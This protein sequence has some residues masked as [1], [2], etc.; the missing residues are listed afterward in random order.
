[1]T[2]SRVLNG[3]VPEIRQQLDQLPAAIEAEKPAG[4]GHEQ[5]SVRAAQVSVSAMLADQKDTAVVNA[6]LSGTAT[7]DGTESTVTVECTV[8]PAT[9]AD[10]AAADARAQA[11]RVAELDAA[12]SK[13][14]KPADVGVV[15]G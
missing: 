10:I 1:M 13:E 9:P 6:R 2:W 11:R 14:S 12:T 4:G 5:R 8:K 15:D 7:A 3:M